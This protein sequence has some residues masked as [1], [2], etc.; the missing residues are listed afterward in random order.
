[1]ASGSGKLS[2]GLLPYRIRDRRIEVFI[3]HMGGP[4]WAAKDEGAWS[5]VK[6]ECNEHEDPLAAARREF[7]EETGY[8][9]PGGGALALGE[10]RQRG[11]KRVLAWAIESDLDPA[12]IKSNTF[13]M[14]WPPGRGLEREFPEIDRADWFETGAARQKLVK[15]QVPFLERLEQ[16]LGA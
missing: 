13:K 9:A 15:G 8:P 7:E 4:F 3:A 11:G 16:A 10:V 12:G 2:A 5:I 1:M 6:G 14:V